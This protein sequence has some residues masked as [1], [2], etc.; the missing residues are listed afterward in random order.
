MVIQLADGCSEG[1]RCNFTQF[2]ALKMQRGPSEHSSPSCMI[3][4]PALELV[5]KSYGLS[6]ISNASRMV[7]RLALELA[8]KSYGLST[9]SNASHITIRLV[10]GCSEGS[11]CNFTYSKALKTQCGPFEHPSATRMVSR[12]ALELGGKS[13]GLPANSNG[14][15]MVIRFSDACSKG[16]RCNFTQY[17][18]LKT[19]RGPS[20]HPSA[21]RMLADGC[22]EGTR[23]NFTQFKALKMQR[24]PSEHS[25]P[26]RMISRLALELVAKSYGLSTSSNASRMISRFALELAAKSYGL[27][28][29][30][31]AS[32]IT[33]WLVDGCSEGSRCNFTYSK[34]LKTQCGPFEHPSASRMVSRFALKLVGKSYGLPANSNA[35]RMVIRFS[36]GY[37]E[38]PRCN[39]TQ[40]KALKTQCGSFEHPSAR[41]MLADGCSKDPRCNFMQSK[42]LKTQRGSSE[43]PS[44]SR[45]VMRLALELANK[46]YDLP[47]SS[48][49]ADG[50]LKD[51][52]CNFMQSKALKTQRGS[53]EHPSASRLV[54]RLAL[55]LANKSYDL[56]ASS[57]I[58]DVC[59]EVLR[60]NFTQSKV[61]KTQCRS[62]EHPSASRMVNRLALELA[63]K[64]YVSRASSNASRMVIQLAYGCSEV[65]HCNFTYSKALKTQREPFEHPSA[66][67]MES[68]LT[69]E[70]AG[71]SYVLP[72][73]SNASH[74]VIQLAD[75]CSE[76]PHCNFTYSKALKTQRG[77]SEHPSASRL[78]MQLTL[79]LAN[80][81]HDLPTS[82]N[83]IHI[84][85]RLVD[86]CSEG[87][88]C[89]FT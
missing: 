70:L 75:G 72:A 68:R 46:S 6:T 62:S 87:P 47:A 9:S 69:L 78:V 44:A 63:D 10:Y 76:G 83:R 64:S 73:S 34:A 60:C 52:R 86:G 30:S 43:H 21:R 12:F 53:S 74:M 3:S 20:E 38:G 89:K 56:P 27:S 36:D 66:I 41:R 61:L 24:G 23:C 42:A 85:I 88:R 28:T 35:S 37:S 54:M 84:T 16:P 14:S 5:G 49:L 33:I 67:R 4:R 81:S 17:K 55:E 58:V 7:S 80:K 15:R 48:N 79:E 40:Y 51:P 50:C 39:F 71:K 29:S 22:S 11:H 26:S 13:Y 1:P 77:T 25:S 59:S 31:N 45:L 32:H 19:Q 57:N 65:P 18:A 2:K 82:S 8:G